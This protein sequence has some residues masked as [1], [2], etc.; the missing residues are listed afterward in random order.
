VGAANG[1]QVIASD[2]AVEAAGDAAGVR[3]EPIGAFRLRDFDR[4]VRLAAVLDPHQRRDDPISVRAVPAEGHNLVAAATSF[5]GREADVDHLQARLQPGRVLTIIGP[6]GMGKT[7]LAVEVGFR[8]APVWSDG[9]WFVDLSTVADERRVIAAV[10]DT[11]GVSPTNG[12]DEQ[13]AVLAHLEGRGALLL[14]DNCEHVHQ[15]T[16]R[17]VATL[18]ARCPR[19]GVLATSRV[20]LALQAEE[21]WRIGPLP[22]TE[23]SVRLF[24]DRG[25]A[26]SPDYA[27][28][29]T[30]ESIV[31]EI[32]R[33]LDGM[34]LAIELAAARLAVLSP[35]EILSGLERRFG[36]LRTTD[37]TAAPRQ[38]SMR[39]LLDWGQALLA[40]ADQMVFRRLSIFRTS[41]DLDAAAAGAGFDGV[42]P[43][44][45]AE[46]V[47]SLADQSLLAV[48]RT[49]G[50]TR[51]RMLETVRAYAADRLS[52]SGD[53]VATR[54]RLAEHYLERF[55]WKQ[56]TSRASLRGLALE[57]DTLA[58]LIEGL[59]DD[60]RSDDALALARM[61][62][63]A[64]HVE[65]HLALA[66]VD[67][68][69]AIERAPLSSSMLARARA[70]AALLAARLGQIDRAECH[71][72]IERQLLAERGPQ[73]R[74]GRVSLGRSEAEIA[75]R[76]N[77]A[78]A[79]A[80]A[81]DQLPSELDEPLAVLDR[82]DVL[83][84]LGE[85]LG[86]LGDPGAVDPLTEAV[87]LLRTLDDEAALTGVLSSLAEHELRRGDVS[88]AARHQRE[89]LHLA[90]ELAAPTPI[91]CAFILAARLAEPA[92]FPETALRLHAAADVLLED[93]GFALFPP[94]QALSDEMRERT[95][96]QLGQE[97]YDTLTRSGRELSLHAAV[98][99][100]DEV[101]AQTI[102]N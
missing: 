21:L 12:D 72:R 64:R 42:D 32:C 97:R 100:A 91:A 74:W 49:T 90:A 67:L 81:A 11:L 28:S 31:A 66:L 51:Y 89:A 5:I 60:G 22:I 57:A 27:W 35:A 99:L 77:D 24:V 87:G 20:A 92:G 48:D 3:F 62:S 79:L 69:H 65:G 98:E 68:E 102:A 54:Q 55:C 45:V 46:H 47:W 16:A 56:V 40:P 59:L 95:R 14:L 37:P 41:F 10:A 36:L 18:G 76:T 8:T 38:R 94:D 29:A 1:G 25:R 34:P 80:L 50:D 75:L 86:D 33:H 30:D 19:V 85:V 73:D 2:D 15:A 39:A 93:V 84:T 101:L 13:A 78:S 23:E 9:V 4:P 7:R 52:E 53:G 26:R 6:G 82:S 61:L 44:D 63:I 71:L 43:E 83:S 70:G 88:S 17:F 58:P 96:R